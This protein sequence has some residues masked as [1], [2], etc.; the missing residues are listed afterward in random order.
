[1]RWLG[2]Q[3]PRDL[4]GLSLYRWLILVELVGKVYPNRS[5][6]PIAFGHGK[7]GW[8][9]PVSG[10]QQVAQQDAAAAFGCARRTQRYWARA[11]N[12]VDG[13]IASMRLTG[14]SRA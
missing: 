10:C 7:A 1:M 3:D 8:F 5:R 12:L 11:Q 6:S 14:L 2:I 13:L 4:C 9:G